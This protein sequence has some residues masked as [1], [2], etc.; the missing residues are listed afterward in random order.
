MNK[1]NTRFTS[2]MLSGIGDAS[3][4]Q[5]LNIETIID[6]P[7]VGLNLQVRGVS[8]FEQRDTHV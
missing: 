2:V 3:V 5:T 1:I 7:D 8:P 6:L 4:L